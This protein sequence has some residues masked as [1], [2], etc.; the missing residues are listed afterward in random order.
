MLISLEETRRADIPMMADPEALKPRYVNHQLTV[1]RY[2]LANRQAL[3]ALLGAALCDWT[4]D[5]HAKVRDRAIG[6]GGVA[7]VGIHGIRRDGESALQECVT[8]DCA[9]GSA[10]AKSG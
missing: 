10:A 7:A 4:A 9:V 1:N 5:P 2:L 3:Q 8:G 6:S